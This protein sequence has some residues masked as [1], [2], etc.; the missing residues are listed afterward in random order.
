MTHGIHAEATG[1]RLS[2]GDTAGIGLLVAGAAA[3]IWATDL[4]IRLQTAADFASYIASAD[5][6]LAGGSMFAP[7]QL[8]GPY[9]LAVSSGQNFGYTP[10]SMLVLVPITRLGFV[11]FTALSVVFLFAGLVAIVALHRPVTLAWSGVV[12]S[13]AFTP[14]FVQAVMLGNVTVVLTGLLAWAYVGRSGIAG[15]LAGLVKLTPASIASLDG[16][17]G[18]ATAAGLAGLISL[19]TLPIV[20]VQN[21][22]DFLVAIGNARPYCE[23]SISVACLSGSTTIAL[24]FGLLLTWASLFARDRLVRLALVTAA[25]LAT[26]MELQPVSPYFVYACP[27]VVAI[28]A[29]L[30]GRSSRPAPGP[31]HRAATVKASS[32]ERPAPRAKVSPAAKLSPQP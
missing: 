32:N 21:W 25:L 24:A 19:A 16:W 20:G 1:R 2:L 13:L 22:T 5:R 26:S 30:S 14:P 17:R 10:P 12:A 11:A 9:L 23:S 7:A 29:S 18:V 6:W 4:A 3:L 8:D 27:L 28:A 15:A 31:P